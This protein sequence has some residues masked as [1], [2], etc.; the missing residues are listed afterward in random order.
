MISYSDN[1]RDKNKLKNLVSNYEALLIK[2]ALY[3]NNGSVQLTAK[4]LGIHR[5][6][7]YKKIENYNIN[8]TIE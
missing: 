2:D 7:L 1:S 4:E 6:L 3:K 8:K 5:S